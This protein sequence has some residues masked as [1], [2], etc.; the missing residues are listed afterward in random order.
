MQNNP[1]QKVSNNQANVQR[2]NATHDPSL[3]PTSITF[4]ASVLGFPLQRGARRF[5]G[6]NAGAHITTLQISATMCRPSMQ[7]RLLPQR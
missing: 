3:S 1:L 6:S 7:Q 2:N 4:A 5:D